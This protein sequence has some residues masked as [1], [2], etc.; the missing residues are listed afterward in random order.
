EG[1]ILLR[2]AA[3]GPVLSFE[4]TDDGAGIDAGAVR[5]TAA[6][7]GLLSGRP[8]IESDEDLLQLLFTPGFTTVRDATTLAGRGVGLDIV[9][10]SVEAFGG[11]VDVR[12]QV[13][14]GTTVTVRVTQ[15]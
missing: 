1:L 3:Q 5:A 15:A 11:R 12:S 4:V 14:K 9:R 7:M 6:E 2:A 13:G 10:S 8:M